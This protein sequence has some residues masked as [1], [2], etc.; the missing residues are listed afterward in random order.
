LLTA[1][2]PACGSS[3]NQFRITPGV[4]SVTAE[5]A[6]TAFGIAMTAFAMGKPVMVLFDSTL[7]G[8]AVQQVYL[9]P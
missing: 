8:C 9:Q 5:G 7:P 1:S 2:N 6:K 3:G 4:N